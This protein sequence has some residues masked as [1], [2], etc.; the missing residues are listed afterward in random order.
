MDKEI[1]IFDCH[2]KTCYI[3]GEES[4]RMT[5]KSTYPR[6]DSCTNN[7]WP[8]KEFTVIAKRKKAKAAEIAVVVQQVVDLLFRTFRS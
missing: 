6:C 3:C 5:V 4:K 2:R 8:A 7:K 1:Y